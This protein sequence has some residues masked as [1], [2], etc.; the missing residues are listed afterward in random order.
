MS[1]FKMGIAALRIAVLLQFVSFAIAA[2]SSCTAVPSVSSC[3]SSITSKI[4]R[5]ASASKWCSSVLGCPV[6]TTTTLTGTVTTTSTTTV[7][8]SYTFEDIGTETTTTHTV[9]WTDTTTQA[10]AT[11]TTRPTWTVE[12]FSVTTIKPKKRWDPDENALE[13]RATA[14]TSVCQSGAQESACSCLYPCAG[15]VTKDSRK[16]QKVIET[17]TTYYITTN[18][19]TVTYDEYDARPTT[20]T[21]PYTW[22]TTKA[23]LATHTRTIKCTPSVSNPSFY[24][25]AT[26]SPLPTPLAFNAKYVRVEPTFDWIS[27]IFIPQYTRYKADATLFTLDAKGRLVTPTAYGDRFS[28]TDDFNSFE[29]FYFLSRKFVQDRLPY[30]PYIVCEL[31]EPSGRFD[32]GYKELDCHG[33]GFWPLKVFQFCPEY[34][35]Y[36]PFGTILGTEL[37]ETSPDCFQVTYLVVPAC[38]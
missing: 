4:S 19:V 6:P 7:T 5:T 12:K 34:L 28:A 2:S 15:P 1:S 27:D 8:E 20:E 31:L 22:T 26:I 3:V 23:I 29:P 17:E 36:Y 10:V 38:G 33:T 14:T 21:F 37:S 13:A 35:R 9:S 16:T 18:Y 30:W 11:V 32:G 25:S 24:L